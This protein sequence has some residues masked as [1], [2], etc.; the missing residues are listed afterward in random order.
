[1]ILAASC[2]ALSNS[3]SSAGSQNRWA[4]SVS[5]GSSENHPAPLSIAE[6]CLWIPVLLLGCLQ[7]QVDSVSSPHPTSAVS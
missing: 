6:F 7:E 3:E 2:L 1:M 4:I 5:A